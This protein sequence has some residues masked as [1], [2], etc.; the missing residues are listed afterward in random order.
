MT[1]RARFA[2]AIGGEGV[3]FAP[4]VW[5]RLPRFV[6]QHAD[7]WWRDGTTV[8]RFL[9]D[10][11]GLARAD[12]MVVG[13]CADA[14]RTVAAGGVVLGPSIGPKLLTDLRRGPAT[15]PPPFDQL[16]PR[17]RE[18]VELVAAGLP[19]KQAAFRL[20]ISRR[21]VE[22]HRAQAMRKL[23]VRTLPELVRLLLDLATREHGA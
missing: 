12:A 9:L 1:G 6:H 3:A 5:E 14:L 19:N 4:Y 8:R 21:T 16:T 23:G 13:A 15:L 7:G 18:I 11:A 2:A 10:V 22:G 17:E 20:G